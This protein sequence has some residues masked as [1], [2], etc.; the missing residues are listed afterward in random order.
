MR[1]RHVVYA[2]EFPN[3]LNSSLRT[4]HHQADEAP[5]PVRGFEQRMVKSSNAA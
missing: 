3:L 2:P 5:V 4:G 1:R